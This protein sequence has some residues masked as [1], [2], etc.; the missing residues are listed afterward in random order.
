MESVVGSAE[1]PQGGK[2]RW[3]TP[4]ALSSTSLC[5]SV[6]LLVSL[7]PPSRSLSVSLSLCDPLLWT[8]YGQHTPGCREDATEDLEPDSAADPAWAPG[9][10]FQPPDSRVARAPGP[11]S[12]DPGWNP[13]L[14]LSQSHGLVH[15]ASRWVKRDHRAPI[16]SG[17]GDYYCHHPTTMIIVPFLKP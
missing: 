7:D 2:E 8:E 15:L 9:S 6:S 11:V 12:G 1:G 3:E 16:S 14:V 17:F 10:R 4:P 13:N 5:A